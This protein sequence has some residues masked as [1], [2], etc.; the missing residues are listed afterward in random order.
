MKSYYF[1]LVAI[2]GSGCRNDS[3]PIYGDRA[4]YGHVSESIQI[5]KSEQIGG[6]NLHL[7]VVENASSTDEQ[8]VPV[9]KNQIVKA[10]IVAAIEPDATTHLLKTKELNLAFRFWVYSYVD[11]N[12]N[13]VLDRNEPFG[14][15]AGNPI[16]VLASESGKVR[17]GGSTSHKNYDRALTIDRRY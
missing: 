12:G 17:V 16:D 8:G 9:G 1:V 4:V 2:L 7:V 14:V 11:L 6:S 15:D 13:G 10:D 3:G 5:I